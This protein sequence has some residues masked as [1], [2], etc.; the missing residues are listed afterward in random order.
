MTKLHVTIRTHCHACPRM[1][2]GPRAR[3]RWANPHQVGAPHRGRWWWM[4]TI[5]VGVDGPVVAYRQNYASYDRV[6][7]AVGRAYAKLVAALAVEVVID[8]V[9]A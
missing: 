6:R 5:R 3:H 7:L 1:G 4:F 8:A 2:V 9:D